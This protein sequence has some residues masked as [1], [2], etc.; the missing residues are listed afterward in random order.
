MSQPRNWKGL[1]RIALVLVCLCSL[2]ALRVFLSNDLFI[3][4]E[5]DHF[6]NKLEIRNANQKADDEI[7]ILAIDEAALKALELQF[8]RWPWERSVWNEVIEYLGTQG[9]KNIYFDMIFSEYSKPPLGGVLDPGDDALLNATISYQ[10]KV[11]HAGQ[12]INEP[13]TEEN[14]RSLNRPF[15]DL[16]ESELFTLPNRSGISRYNK[17]IL[18]FDELLAVSN[19]IGSID[20]SHDVDGV[21][22]RL[23]PLRSYSDY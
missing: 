8:G 4:L 12:V 23:I 15:S 9:V 1:K 20:V 3:K 7:I 17:L 10:D 18:A 13:E 14:Y 5:L 2:A 6:D 11:V 16:V 21:Y 19:F 22:R